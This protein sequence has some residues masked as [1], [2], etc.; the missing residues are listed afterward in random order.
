[1]GWSTWRQVR[2]QAVRGVDVERIATT[3]R[4]QWPRHWATGEIASIASLFISDVDTEVDTRLDKIAAI[5]RRLSTPNTLRQLGIADLL[6]A[7]T[8][9]T[10]QDSHRGFRA[11]LPRYPV[12]G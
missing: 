2:D 1:M 5:R 7:R 4:S 6:S 11:P 9:R 3:R 12:E 8:P 10:Q